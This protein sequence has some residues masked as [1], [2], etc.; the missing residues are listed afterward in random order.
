MKTV[1]K[2][3]IAILA[4][5]GLSAVSAYLGWS[6]KPETDYMVLTEEVQVEVPE[7][8]KK[9]LHVGI[10]ADGTITPFEDESELKSEGLEYIIEL[11][12]DVG[13]GELVELY[14]YLESAD[15]DYHITTIQVPTNN[16]RMKIT[17]K[18]TPPVDKED[19]F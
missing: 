5:A 10:Y 18:F 12:Y 9:H 13:D 6:G 17:K 16:Y 11:Y 3:L 4:V 8:Y 19:S 14:I 2:W 7:T 1:A 15:G